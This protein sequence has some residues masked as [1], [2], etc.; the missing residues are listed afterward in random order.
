MDTTK[1]KKFAQF[2]RRTLIGQIGAKL[3]AVIA[4]NS[5][6]RR[7]S[8][9]TVKELEGQIF[10]HGRDQVVERV[11]Y[12]WFNRFSALRY[13]DV[14][15]LNSVRVVSPLPGQFQPEIL[16]EAKAGNID[17]S[18]VPESVRDQ[19]HALLDGRAPSQNPHAEAYRLLLVAMC[20]DWHEAMPFL[21][22]KITDYTELLMPE[23]LLSIHSILAYTR[24]AMTP[25]ACE[26]VEIIGWLYQ[27]YVSEKKDEVFAGLKKNKKVTPENIPAATQLYT[28]HWIVRYLV[29]NSLGRLWMLNRPFSRLIKKMDY[30][31][32]PEEQEEDFLRLSSPEEIKVCDPACGSGHMLTYAFDLLYAIYEEEG[33]DPSEIPEK[34]L[35]KNLYGIEID[36]R[37]GA[38]AAF[39]LAMKAAGRR[40]RFLGRMG[41]NGVKPNICV[42]ENVSFKDRELADYMKKIGNDLFIADLRETLGQFAEVKNFGSLIVPKIEDV[43]EIRRMIA[44]KDLQGDMFYGDVHARVLTVLRMADYLGPKYHAVVANPPYMA[45]PNMNPLL[46]RWISKQFPNSKADLMTCFMERASTMLHAR[47]FW[48][49]INLPSWL[50]NF[51]NEELRNWLIKSNKICAMAYF[52]RGVFGSD[53]GSV[54]TVVC[55]RGLVNNEKTVFLKLFENH[56]DV[57][58][59]KTIEKIFVNNQGGRYV[60]NQLDLFGIPGT[61]IAFWAAPKIRETFSRL[62]ALSESGVAASGIQTSDNELYLRFWHEVSLI[63]IFS[64]TNGFDEVHAPKAWVPHN[65]GGAFRRWYGNQE[66]VMG[67]HH[68]GNQ[69]KEDPKFQQKN[70]RYQMKEAATWSHTSSGSFSVRYSPPGRSFNVEGRFSSIRMM[71]FLA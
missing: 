61:P 13:M 68:S 50:F 10:G 38:L 9:K 51:S 1:I 22:E 67:W 18:R 27:F 5:P 29:E 46:K 23:D 7:E 32:V 40:K 8:P 39:A 11:A 43:T 28:P 19:I 20:N 31:I 14:T 63:D 56:V 2:A 36:E 17:G 30:Y 12:T 65:K 52:G 42:L 71:L 64:C 55:K 69:A 37:A 34:I 49:I 58:S 4:E 21:F 3:D 62:P 47:G 48:S 59:N 54:A 24:E 25:D 6:S 70:M 66:Y 60:V 15:Y 45:A 57:R 35:T 33:Y 26:D 41:K 44:A 16:A 53:F